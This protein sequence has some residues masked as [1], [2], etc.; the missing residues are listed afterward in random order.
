MGGTIVR[1]AAQGHHL[2]LLDMTNGE[3]TPH[4]SPEQRE[5][6]WT[7]AV[8]ILGRQA[9]DAGGGGTIRRRLLGLPNREVVH[10]IQA[11]HMVAGVIREHRAQIVF[12]PFAED[13]HPDHVATT[14]IVE[15]ARFDAKLTKVDLPGQPIYPK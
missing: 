12:L 9:K 1:L 15:D 13:A 7:A 3:P 11:R 5:K 10:S 14:R 6:E 2:L 4:G 8:E